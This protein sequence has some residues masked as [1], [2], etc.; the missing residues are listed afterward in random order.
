MLAGYIFWGENGLSNVNN[1]G[2]PLYGSRTGGTA[3]SYYNLS[4]AA[5]ANIDNGVVPYLYQLASQ[6]TLFDSFFRST[7][8]ASGK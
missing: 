8:G 5:N 3:F 2:F 4:L 6:Y 7:N 1:P